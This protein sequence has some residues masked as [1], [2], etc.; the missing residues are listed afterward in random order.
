MMVC[1]EPRREREEGLGRMCVTHASSSVV[2]KAGESTRAGSVPVD[3]QGESAGGAG[4]VL[5]AVAEEAGYAE[6][7]TEASL[8]GGDSAVRDAGRERVSGGEGF[9][10]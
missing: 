4:V 10:K 1:C 2:A 8:V 5:P 3:A 9:G 6:A 7:S